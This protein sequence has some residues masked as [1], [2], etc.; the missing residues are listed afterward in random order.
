[1]KGE[2]TMTKRTVAVAAV[3]ALALAPGAFAQRGAGV[4]GLGAGWGRPAG[5]MMGPGSGFGA[6]RVAVLTQVLDLTQDQLAAWQPLRDQAQAAIKPLLDQMRQIGSDV[7]SALDAGGADPA[8]IGA[9]M[10]AV[11]D[12]RT[13][14]KAARDAEETAFRGLLTDAQKAKLDVLE[15]LRRSMGPGRGIGRAMGPGAQGF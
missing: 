3:F 15:Q 4:H 12:L 14:I 7:R 8:T 9:K 2:T 5:A 13:K 11:H 6:R 1:M 10:I